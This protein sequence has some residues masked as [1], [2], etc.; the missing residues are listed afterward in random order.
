[1][2]RK[3][4]NQTKKIYSEGNIVFVFLFI[5]LLFVLPFVMFVEFMTKFLF[6]FIK[7]SIREGSGS[8]VLDSRQ[9]GQG[10]ESHRCRCVLSL[11]KTHL[12]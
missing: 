10:F 4:S 9:R 1:M 2:G 6:K 8:V 3:D 12:S 7:W 11:N 5:L